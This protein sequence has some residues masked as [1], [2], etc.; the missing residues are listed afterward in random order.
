M[1][2][3]LPCNVEDLGSIP[4]QGTKIPRATEQLR[5]CEA[6]KIPHDAMKCYV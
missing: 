6:R 3:S 1:V 2:K 5:L 4:G